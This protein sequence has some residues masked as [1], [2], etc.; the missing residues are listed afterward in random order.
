M[1]TECCEEGVHGDTGRQVMPGPLARPANEESAERGS[2]S[3]LE[4]ADVRWTSGHFQEAPPRR[5]SAEGD[6]QHAAVRVILITTA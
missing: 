3:T 2:T 5:S 4:A 6:G 1:T